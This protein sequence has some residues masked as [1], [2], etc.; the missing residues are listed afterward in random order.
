[1]HLLARPTREELEQFLRLRLRERLLVQ[2]AGECE[3]VYVGRAASLT[4]AG[5][6]LVAAAEAAGTVL[7]MAEAGRTPYLTGGT[8]DHR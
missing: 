2:V 6:R 8:H 5:D 4:E 3:V 1:M 7:T